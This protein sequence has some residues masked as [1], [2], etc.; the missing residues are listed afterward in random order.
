[1]G[2]QTFANQPSLGEILVL[3]IKQ[4][5]G[6]V[7]VVVFLVPEQFEGNYIAALGGNGGLQQIGRDRERL[8]SRNRRSDNRRN[9]R[10]LG[11]Q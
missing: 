10:S 2:R 11:L 3:G 5:K 4:D 9:G 8:G 6:L 7:L 1:M